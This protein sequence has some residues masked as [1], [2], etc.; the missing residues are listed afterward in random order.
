[1]KAVKSN[2]T[3]VRCDQITWKVLEETRLFFNQRLGP[4]DFTNKGP[5]R[6]PTAD[7]GGLIEDVRCNKILDYVTIPRQWKN[8]H[9]GENGPPTMARGKRLVFKPMGH[10]T[11]PCQ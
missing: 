4:N 8:Q 6:F 7:L 11:V 3:R 1:M 10:L 5:R 2:F 9:H